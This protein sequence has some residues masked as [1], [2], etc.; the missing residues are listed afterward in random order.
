MFISEN[1]SAYK[2]RFKNSIVVQEIYIYRI[3]AKAYSKNP[4]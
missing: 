2:S 3:G 1:M 4:C